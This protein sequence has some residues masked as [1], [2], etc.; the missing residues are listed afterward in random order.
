M[1]PLSSMR[2]D[3]DRNIV[4]QR[5]TVQYRAEAGMAQSL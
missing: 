3:V 5:M 1:G 2:S 4:M